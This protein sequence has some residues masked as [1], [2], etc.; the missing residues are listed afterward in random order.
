VDGGKVNDARGCGGIL[1][2]IPFLMPCW[3]AIRMTGINGI[4][5]P[6]RD[7]FLRATV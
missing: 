3:G 7:P 2:G 1:K 4:A 6:T 5:I